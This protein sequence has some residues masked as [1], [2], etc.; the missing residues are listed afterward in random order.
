MIVATGALSCQDAAVAS[1]IAAVVDILVRRMAHGCHLLECALRLLHLA[2]ACSTAQGI[3]TRELSVVVLLH[4]S[5]VHFE[6]NSVL[7]TASHVVLV[8]CAQWCA[9]ACH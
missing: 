3:T 2:S 9:V 6:C 4:T 8:R 7:S 5:H 1:T